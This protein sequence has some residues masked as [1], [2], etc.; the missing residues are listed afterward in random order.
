MG[1]LDLGFVGTQFTWHKHFADGHL[2][3]ERLDRGLANSEWILQFRGTRVHYLQS[4]NFDHHPLWI[5]PAGL[6]PPSA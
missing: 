2:V 4:N 3:W 1:F 6:D 5:V